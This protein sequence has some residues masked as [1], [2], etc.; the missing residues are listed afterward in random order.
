MFYS[1]KFVPIYVSTYPTHQKPLSIET[2]FL[3]NHQQN[4]ENLTYLQEH[5]LKL[6]NP[7]TMLNTVHI[8]YISTHMNS[9][10]TQ[11]SQEL[12]PVHGDHQ[13]Q[14]KILSEQ[15]ISEQ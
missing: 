8:Q 14:Y 13:V 10:F 15:M 7:K 2:W 9:G 3:Y 12:P 4:L 1:L 6:L 5:H 11:P